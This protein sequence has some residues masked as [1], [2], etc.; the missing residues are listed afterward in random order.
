MNFGRIN[1]GELLIFLLLIAVNVLLQFAPLTSEFGYEFALVNSVLLWIGG[2]FLIINFCKGMR[3]D[4]C[5]LYNI[6]SSGLLPLMLFVF[7]PVLV[8]FLFNIGS[9]C[10]FSFG[11]KYYLVFSFFSFLYAILF[12]SS[13]MRIGIRRKRLFFLFST[14]TLLI[15]PLIEIYYYPQIYS[16][17]PLLGYFPGTIYDEFIPIT[18]K[19]ILY[20]IVILIIF[21][22]FYL[23]SSKYYNLKALAI[24]LGL[25]LFFLVFLKPPL[26]FDTNAARLN[27]ETFIYSELPELQMRFFYP[28]KK[29]EII[30]KTME[31][32]FLLDEIK[33]FTGINNLSPINS[34]LYSDDK[35]KAELFG[36]A[37]ADVSKPW[38]R[39]VF[40][41][42]NTSVSTIKHELAHAVSANFGV[43][44]TKLAADF[45]P[46]LIEGF[47]VAA[48]NDILNYPVDKVAALIYKSGIEINL[49]NLFSGFRFFGSSPAFGYLFAGAFVQYLIN[50]YGFNKFREYY[51]TNKFSEIYGKSFTSA[52]T[53]FKRRLDSIKVADAPQLTKILLGSKSV[54]NR[55]CRHYAA[56]ELQ[57][58]KDLLKKE[59]YS[60]AKEIYSDLYYHYNKPQ[61]L[62]GL[63]NAL[64]ESDN[65][66]GALTLLETAKPR[67]YNSSFE[68]RFKML[69]AQVYILN[70]EQD[71]ARE[72]LL[73][74][75]SSSPF[76]Y[77]RDMSR[78]FLALIKQYNNS[79]AEYLKLNGRGK[80]L[81]LKKLFEKT[82][83]E[84]FLRGLIPYSKYYE[85][86]NLLPDKEKTFAPQTNYL[87]AK[88]FL[89]K[90]DFNRAKY[91]S[92][93]LN[94]NDCTLNIFLVLNLKKEIKWFYE[95]RTMA[96]EIVIR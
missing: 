60:D 89:R 73:N 12:A 77:Y 82:E 46:A 39:S 78:L 55:K 95:N 24:G 76:F 43:G 75:K 31:E 92:K 17:S 93:K 65:K 32:K 3:K 30:Y 19:L 5:G 51:K 10:P 66:K 72:V 58:A 83:D 69:L 36:S 18:E 84:I 42:R 15:I 25:Y 62:F 53:E 11:V 38:Q 37:A 49:E 2:G 61:A 41:E 29:K 87:L 90:I 48:E 4:E 56:E 9:L 8:S 22:A 79:A 71:S 68:L 59:K 88:Y 80:F 47:A 50:E 74:L 33:K 54:F 44:F 28:A 34:F 64:L 96:D 91:Y 81:L 7:V 70:G 57:R 16:Y 35:Q 20:R 40:I 21:T 6:I 67:M 86:I 27:T 94:G 14:L 13:L 1:K 85:L 23:L 45:N 26:G 63:A 52:E